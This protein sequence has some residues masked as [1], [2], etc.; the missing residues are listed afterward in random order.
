MLATCPTATGHGPCRALS[1][2]TDADNDRGRSLRDHCRMRLRRIVELTA[3][4]AN[5]GFT[6]PVEAFRVSGRVRTGTT[7]RLEV[8]SAI[9]RLDGVGPRR[10]HTREE[11]TQA[12]LKATRRYSV[13]TIRRILCYDLVG[14]ST[15]HHVVSRDLERV[16][17]LFRRL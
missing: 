8:L 5:Q 14:R 13:E 7:C 3:L 1:L 2:A 11:I 4:F 17:S 15:S 9:D 6:A 10:W 12:V 16:G